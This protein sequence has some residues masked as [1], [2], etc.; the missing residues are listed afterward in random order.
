MVNLGM[1]LEKTSGP[2][3]ASAEN[4]LNLPSD[5][6]INT[7][8]DEAFKSFT[9]KDGI[10][11]T[12]VIDKNGYL[13]YAGASVT[14]N[15]PTSKAVVALDLAIGYSDLDSSIKGIEYFDK[16]KT[17]MYKDATVIPIMQYLQ[18]STNLTGN[19]GSTPSS[20]F[21]LGN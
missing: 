1:E 21:G 8:I 20:L 6:E 5:Q 13:S 15:E 9:F 11:A 7:Q 17:G 4:K 16:N 2:G 18:N 10:N 19:A 3:T 14:M 12:L